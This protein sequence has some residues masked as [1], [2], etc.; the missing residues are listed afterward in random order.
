VPICP[1]LRRTCGPGVRVPSP[2]CD[3]GNL[4]L[5]APACTPV[6]A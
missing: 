6:P 4:A 3:C 1:W 2:I 5:R